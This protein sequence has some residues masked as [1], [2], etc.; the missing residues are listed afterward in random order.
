MNVQQPLADRRIRQRCG[1]RLERAPV[2]GIG[3][4]LMRVEFIKVRDYRFLPL[5]LSVSLPQVARIRACAR[6]V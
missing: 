4:L 2:L 3:P 5:I 6:A 1:M